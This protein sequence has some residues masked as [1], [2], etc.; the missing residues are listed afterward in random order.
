MG[1]H[2]APSVT[3]PPAAPSPEAGGTGSLQRWGQQGWA[4][5]TPVACTACPGAQVCLSRRAPALRCE[6]QLLQQHQGGRTEGGGHAVMGGK[7]VFCSSAVPGFQAGSARPGCLWEALPGGWRQPLTPGHQPWP[8]SSP[9]SGAVHTSGGQCQR[10]PGSHSRGRFPSP[11]HSSKQRTGG[12]RATG[13][14]GQQLLALPKPREPQSA[15]ASCPQVTQGALSPPGLLCG[16]GRPAVPCSGLGTGLLSLACPRK[17]LRSS[18][19]AWVS[20]TC[21]SFLP[22]CAGHTTSGSIIPSMSITPP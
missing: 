16:Q 21:P 19:G 2:A 12:M 5:G 18:W 7:G 17:G 22:H 6:L 11:A 4:L 14:R 8:G 13:A 1:R 9:R 10:L 15:A 3:V 20:H